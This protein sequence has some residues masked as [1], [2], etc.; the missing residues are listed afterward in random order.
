MAEA[1]EKEAKIK[2]ASKQQVLDWVVEAW[3][4]I[5]EKKELIVKSFQVTGI[6]STVQLTSNLTRSCESLASDSQ[7]SREY[8]FVC[9][10]GRPS[11]L[12]RTCWSAREEGL[13]VSRVRVCLLARKGWWSRECVFVCSRGRA[14]GLASTCSRDHQPFL[15]STRTSCAG[16]LVTRGRDTF[17]VFPCRCSRRREILQLFALS[18]CSASS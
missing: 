13:V 2:T 15:A 18:R 8:V 3:K 17:V 1:A 7:L 6:I 4:T 12:A 14:G 10:R 11:G 16:M 9:T 5:K